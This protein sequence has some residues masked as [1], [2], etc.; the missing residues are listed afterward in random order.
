MAILRMGSRMPPP[1]GPDNRFLFGCPPLMIG[2][3]VV[4]PTPADVQPNG[5]LLEEITP[6][7]IEP[8]LPDPQAGLRKPTHVLISSEAIGR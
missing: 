2:P 1:E 3:R 4:R 5:G 8:S 7:A 6:R